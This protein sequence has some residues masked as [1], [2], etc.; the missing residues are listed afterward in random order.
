MGEWKEGIWLGVSAFI[1]AML[2][3]FSVVMGN[4]AKQIAR[5][6]QKELDT[7]SVLKEDRKWVRYDNVIVNQADVINCILENRSQVPAVAATAI[8][9]YDNPSASFAYNYLWNGTNPPADYSMEILNLCIPP[10]ST[11]RARLIKDGNGA[12]VYIWF[13]R[14]S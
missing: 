14:I 5:F 7:I 12:V 3:T 1:T 10:G 9:A 8:P 13:R 11:Y 2:L 6:Q 4:E